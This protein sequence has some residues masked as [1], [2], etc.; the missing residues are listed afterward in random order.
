M[1]G[2]YKTHLRKWTTVQ[3]NTVT[4]ICI[5]TTGSFERDRDKIFIVIIVDTTTTT[6]TTTT[7]NN[8]NN[9]RYATK[10]SHTWNITHNTESTAV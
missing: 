4:K 1:Y 9:N 8:N 6:T 10:D 3:L 5:K 2:L 7:T